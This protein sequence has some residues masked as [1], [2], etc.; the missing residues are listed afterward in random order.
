MGVN[1][2]KQFE[3]V[4]R[5]CFEQVEGVS[6][7]RLND[8]TAGFK[9]VAGICDFIVFKSPLLLYLEC[10]SCYGNTLNFHNITE[11]QWEGML[12]KSKIKGV[13]A[14]V[15][16]WFMDRDKTIFIP[17]QTLQLMKEEGLKSVNINMLSEDEYLEIPGKKK[18]V[19]FDYNFY[20]LLVYLIFHAFEE[21]WWENGRT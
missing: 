5:K 19:F 12:E 9:G 16:I 6:I 13:V 14:G 7:D 11:T 4:I 3:N 21:K 2:G 20:P 8:N 18:R 10:K 1:R 17:I 15:V